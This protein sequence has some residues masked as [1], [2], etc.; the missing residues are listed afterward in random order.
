MIKP[1]RIFVVGHMGA[2]KALFSEALMSRLPKNILV[3]RKTGTLP[4]YVSEVAV[5]QM[6]FNAGH[7]ILSI[8]IKDSDK[9]IDVCENIIAETARF[10]FDYITFLAKMT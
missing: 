1:K 5:I 2:G 9:P 3:S 8:Y 6:P 4:G 7:L 10:I